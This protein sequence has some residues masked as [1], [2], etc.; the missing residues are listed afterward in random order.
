MEAYGS[1]AKVYD[2]FMDNVPYERW[3]EHLQ[4]LLK[5][6]GVGQGLVAELGC[7]T[8]RMT[9][10]LA[11]AGYDMIGIDN[12]CEM[13]EE[14]YGAGADGILY[15]NQDI[16]RPCVR[17]FVIFHAKIVFPVKNCTFHYDNLRLF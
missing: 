5:Q 2:L 9:R 15:L 7:G 14:A 4:S 3:G 6:Y 17:H 12:S 16:F 13:L 1:F 10:I 11:G 8:G